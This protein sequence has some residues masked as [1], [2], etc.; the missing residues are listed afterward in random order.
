MQRGLMIAANFGWCTDWPKEVRTQFHLWWGTNEQVA[1][2]RSVTLPE[3]PT[4]P[5]TEPLTSRRINGSVQT[6]PNLL[7]S[8]LVSP[9]WHDTTSTVCR[10][11]EH[12]TATVKHGTGTGQVDF[13]TFEAQQASLPEQDIGPYD[14]VNRLMPMI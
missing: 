3:T 8:S 14:T 13:V 11:D 6:L 4:L 7:E 10:I 2:R 12:P 9:R 1:R 5:Q